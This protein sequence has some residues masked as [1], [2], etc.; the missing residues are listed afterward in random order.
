MVLADHGCRDTPQRRLRSRTPGEW[1]DVR[2]CG[3]SRIDA[4]AG[5]RHDGKP[6]R[7]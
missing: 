3:G 4:A 6:S 1:V 7:Q 5:D 2:E